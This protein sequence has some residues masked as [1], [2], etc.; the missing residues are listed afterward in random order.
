MLANSKLKFS[1]YAIRRRVDTGSETLNFKFQVSNFK[2][3]V[4][5][6]TFNFSKELEAPVSA[7]TLASEVKQTQFKLF[8]KSS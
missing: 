7:A 1:K 5:V 4:P 2:F 6:S 8:H 3:Q